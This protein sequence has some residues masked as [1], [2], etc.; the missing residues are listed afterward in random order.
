M[1]HGTT[2]ID[3]DDRKILREVQRDCTRSL[4]R[5][6][7]RVGLSRTTVWNRMQKLVANGTIIRQ[8]A[9]VDARKVGLKQTF[10]VTIST[11]RHDIEWL[12]VFR[13]AVV[14]MPE[15]IEAHRLAG[16]TDYLLKV[17]VTSTEAFDNFYKALVSRVSIFDVSSS[18]SMEE[19]KHSLDLP[20]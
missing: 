10:F 5:I 19:L 2:D 9:I 20:L 6:A 13:S 11:S 1:S 18:L 17:Q 12:E 14:E 16:T 15:I 3:E 7:E 8:A 4:D